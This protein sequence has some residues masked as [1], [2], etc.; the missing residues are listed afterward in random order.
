MHDKSAWETRPDFSNYVA[1]FT[2]EREPLGN[3]QQAGEEVDLGEIAKLSAYERLVAILENRKIL[4]TPIPWTG[5]RA[6]AFTECPW[7]SLLRHAEAYSPYGVGFVKPRLYAAGGGPAL[8]LRPD[9]VTNQHLYHEAEGG[10]P[11]KGFARNL[12]GFVTLFVPPYAPASVV[13]E[14]WKGRKKVDYSHEREWRVPHDFTVEYT[15]VEFVVVD[16][17]EDVAKFPAQLKDEIGRDK[18]LIMAI[19]RGIN[20]R[21]PLA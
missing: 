5:R 3:Q 6:V 1:H 11:G 12:W 18:F 19:Y 21:W 7:G 8:Y 2:S 16:T 13:T 17:Y 14:H 10:V 15:Q 9:L 20:S 4:A